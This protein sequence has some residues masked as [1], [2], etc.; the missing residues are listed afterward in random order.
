[1]IVDQHPVLRE[2]PRGGG[3]VDHWAQEVAGLINR[4]LADAR[5]TAGAQATLTREIT[6]QLVDRLGNPVRGRWRVLIWIAATENGDPSATGNTVSFTTGV[7]VAHTANAL[8]E[9][10]TDAS[11]KAVFDLTLSGAGTRHVYTVTHGAAAGS[12]SLTWA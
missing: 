7:A 4:P 3:G 5:F 8:Y 6:V 9:V 2:S 1:M 10:M 11:G 12:G